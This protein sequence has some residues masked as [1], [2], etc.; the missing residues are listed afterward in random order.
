MKYVLVHPHRVGYER[1]FYNEFCLSALCV[2]HGFVS[3]T[4]KVFPRLINA[5]GGFATY[6]LRISY[7]WLDLINPAETF[8]DIVIDY[9]YV[10]CTSAAIQA[11][12]SFRKLYPEHRTEE[13]QNC[14]GRV[15]GFIKKMQAEDGSWFV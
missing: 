3:C 12:A 8:G 5:D 2:E 6:E 13:I 11:L 10:E 15:V 1:S 4:F 14:I 7:Q 9:L